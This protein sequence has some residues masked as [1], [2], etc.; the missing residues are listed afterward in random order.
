[1]HPEN[2]AEWAFERIRFINQYR[3]K[4]EKVKFYKATE[5][6]FGKKYHRIY[7]LI[8][9]N[10]IPIFKPH[11]ELTDKDRLTNALYS[12]DQT[13]PNYQSFYSITYTET[14]IRNNYEWITGLFNLLVKDKNLSYEIEQYKSEEEKERE[15][16]WEY[17]ADTRERERT[18]F[19]KDYKPI[20]NIGDIALVEDWLSR[21]KE[22]VEIISTTE[23]E[24]SPYKGVLLRMKLDKGSRTV[25]YIS[26]ENI[27]LSMTRK[28]LNDLLKKNKGLKN[29]KVLITYLNNKTETKTEKQP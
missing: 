2:I 6:Y 13:V 26:E 5:E 12:F 16:K 22:L 29:K 20:V 11:S 21:K 19:F 18:E 23:V 7:F 17:E 1:M 27:K 3:D 28:E 9:T 25:D 14:E 8:Q 24:S 10:I 4:I 15:E